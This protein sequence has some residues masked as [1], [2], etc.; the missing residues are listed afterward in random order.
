[1]NELKSEA[2]KLLI[3]RRFG[4][5]DEFSGFPLAYNRRLNFLLRISSRR[6]K[7]ETD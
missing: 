7:V 3:V 1:V 6:G 4:I 2:G 5:H